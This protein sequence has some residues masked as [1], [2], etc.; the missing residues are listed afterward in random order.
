M[1]DPI[2][3]AGSGMTAQARRLAAGA[4][5]IA[6]ARSTGALPGSAAGAPAGATGADTP[7]PYAPVSSGQ[8]AVTGPDGQG[9][10]TR[11]VFRAT[12]P[13]FVP[14]FSPDSPFA[15]ADGMVAAPN[16]DLVGE[17][18]A[19]TQGLDAYKANLRVFE[20]ADELTREAL[21]LTA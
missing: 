12:Q 17:T 3:I 2:A 9:M 13:A 6:N 4:D 7:R 5:N 19:M 14:E 21:N 1:V 15:D 8:T 10:G 20:A 16:V 11:A 18:V